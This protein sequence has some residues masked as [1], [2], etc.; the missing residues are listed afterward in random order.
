MWCHSSRFFF[1]KILPFFLIWEDTHP[2]FGD[3]AH[4]VMNRRANKPYANRIPRSDTFH[5]VSKGRFHIGIDCIVPQGAKPGTRYVMMHVRHLKG[6]GAS[7]VLEIR[8]IDSSFR[9]TVLRNGCGTSEP[10]LVMTIVV[11]LE[12]HNTEPDV[13]AEAL[14][15]M[16][17]ALAVAYGLTCGGESWAV[18]DAADSGGAYM[19]TTIPFVVPR[20]QFEVHHGTDE[21]YQPSTATKVIAFNIRGGGT[22]YSL[23]S[24]TSTGKIHVAHNAGRTS[25]TTTCGA[26]ASHPQCVL[27]RILCAEMS[28]GFR[29]VDVSYDWAM[30]ATRT[31][32]VPTNVKINLLNAPLMLQHPTMCF[33]VY[34]PWNSGNE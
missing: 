15:R 3:P 32:A 23:P 21:S 2:Y 24:Y 5:E 33:R 14:R 31:C 27:L 30:P 29:T 17:A 18:N 26:A 22:T 7:E 4:Q 28:S 20:N 12:P 11:P 25:Y 8:M 16:M 19:T 6:S 10:P 1:L 9:G 34:P 13:S